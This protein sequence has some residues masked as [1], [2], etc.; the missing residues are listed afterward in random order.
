MAAS[1]LRH[2]RLLH[3]GERL[4]SPRPDVSGV[5]KELGPKLVLFEN[6]ATILSLPSPQVPSPYKAPSTFW[7]TKHLNSC[8]LG[9]S[10]RW[11]TAAGSITTCHVEPHRWGMKAII[12]ECDVASAEV[13]PQVTAFN[14]MIDLACASETHELYPGSPT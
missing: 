11:D 3:S 12:G 4:F 8:W 7:K 14:L 6:T 9:A 13:G 1:T 5:G 10:E 2:R